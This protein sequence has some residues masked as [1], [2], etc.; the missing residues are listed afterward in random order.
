MCPE[1]PCSLGT[2]G[3]SVWGAQHLLG[4]GWL[5]TMG[6]LCLEP[7]SVPGGVVGLVGKADPLPP[8]AHPTHT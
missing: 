3:D 8:A 6:S 7:G 5:V 2:E 1:G 4:K